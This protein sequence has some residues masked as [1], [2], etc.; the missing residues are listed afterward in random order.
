MYRVA[1]KFADKLR[2]CRFPC[3]FFSFKHDGFVLHNKCS[4]VVLGWASDQRKG[5]FKTPVTRLVWLLRVP[6]LPSFEAHKI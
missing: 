3:T 4:L 2:L 6:V 5:V 1:L